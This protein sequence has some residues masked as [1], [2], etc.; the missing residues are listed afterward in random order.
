MTSTDLNNNLLQTCSSQQNTLLQ[1][2]L[3]KDLPVAVL[4]VCFLFSSS[5]MLYP[6]YLFRVFDDSQSFL[7][8]YLSLQMYM[9]TLVPIEKLQA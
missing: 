8:M 2:Q 6:T 1:W 3:E 9:H 7:D 5:R 4:L